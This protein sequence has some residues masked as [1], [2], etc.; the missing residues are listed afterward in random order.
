MRKLLLCAAALFAACGSPVD[1][2]VGSYSVV[3]VSGTRTI[4]GTKTPFGATAAPGIKLLITS[5]AAAASTV[6]ISLGAQPFLDGTV[7]SG[8]TLNTFPWATSFDQDGCSYG[9][10]WAEGKSN[11]TLQGNILQIVLSGSIDGFC[12][13]KPDEHGTAVEQLQATKD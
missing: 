7:T 3:G 10:R 9:V 13:S 12:V 8:T 6:H 5:D 11:G 2:F 4:N 1:A